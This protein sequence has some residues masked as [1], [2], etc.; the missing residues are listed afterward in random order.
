M[1]HMLFCETAAIAIPSLCM[2]LEGQIV[3]SHS[4]TFGKF[5]V[6]L[7]V[8]IAITWNVVMIDGLGLVG[9]CV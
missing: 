1:E 5:V 9:E 6:V 7:T 2:R 4:C 3:Y 8:Y